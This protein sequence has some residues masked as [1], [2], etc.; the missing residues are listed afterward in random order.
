MLRVLEPPQRQCHGVL[1]GNSPILSKLQGDNFT[2]GV[3]A[4]LNIVN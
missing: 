1:G 4:S 2:V 3:A